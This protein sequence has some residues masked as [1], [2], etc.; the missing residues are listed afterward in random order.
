[1]AKANRKK[2]LAYHRPPPNA[3]LNSEEEVTADPSPGMNLVKL[4]KAMVHR[5]ERLHPNDR[6]IPREWGVFYENGEY[7]VRVG[8]VTPELPTDGPAAE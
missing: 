6:R 2:P 4:I 7:R 8:Y 3:K 5:K 1:M